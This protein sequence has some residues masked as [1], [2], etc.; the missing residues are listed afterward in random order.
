MKLHKIINTLNKMT[1]EVYIPRPQRGIHPHLTISYPLVDGIEEIVESVANLLKI[2]QLEP[3]DFPEIKISSMVAMMAVLLEMKDKLILL[4]LFKRWAI[5]TRID[6]SLLAGVVQSLRIFDIHFNEVYTIRA[7]MYN[8][9]TKPSAYETTILKIYPD[10]KIEVQPRRIDENEVKHHTYVL[11]KLRE[12]TS[13]GQ[14]TNFRTMAQY[15]FSCKSKYRS[16]QIMQQLSYFNTS[17]YSISDGKSC[18]GNSFGKV[19]IT[20]P[21]EEEKGEESEESEKS[22]ESEESDESEKEEE[23]EEKN[24]VEILSDYVD[25]PVW[26]RRIEG[27]NPFEK[28]EKLTICTQEKTSID[29]ERWQLNSSYP[30]FGSLPTSPTSSSTCTDS[31]DPNQLFFE[32]PETPPLAKSIKVYS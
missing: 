26:P 10:G 15:D 18:F 16:D 12:V 14:P 3:E 2:E 28:L 8:Y 21:E 9:I 4:D 25:K 23:E 7:A 5:N 17:G 24:P 6:D 22:E 11:K 13:L 30:D 32:F 20:E 31:S 27:E 1:E 19:R 29:K